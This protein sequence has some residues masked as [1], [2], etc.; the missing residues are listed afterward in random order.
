MSLKCMECNSRNSATNLLNF[1]KY[2]LGPCTSKHDGRSWAHKEKLAFLPSNSHG[3]KQK[4]KS[5]NCNISQHPHFYSRDQS[6]TPDASS[7]SRT[8][9]GGKVFRPS[10]KQGSWRA[11]QSQE[12]LRKLPEYKVSLGSRTKLLGL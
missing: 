4:R 6:A 11:G 9:C 2:L 3:N 8:F 5:E 10:C 1:L 12:T 7:R